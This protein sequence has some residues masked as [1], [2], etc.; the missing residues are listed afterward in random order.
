MTQKEVFIEP[1]LLPKWALTQFNY[2]N[3]VEMFYQ[4]L[5]KAE[6]NKERVEFLI[7]SILHK[8]TIIKSQTKFF[9]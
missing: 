1:T 9:N 8:K 7:N 3:C 5:D 4:E 6:P 2:N